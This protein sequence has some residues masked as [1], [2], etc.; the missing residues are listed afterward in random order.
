M[1]PINA[2][3]AA[4]YCIDQGTPKYTQAAYFILAD[5]QNHGQWPVRSEDCL[6]SHRCH[7]GYCTMHRTV[8][9]ELNGSV[10]DISAQLR[11]RV[12]WE[13]NGYVHRRGDRHSFSSHIQAMIEGES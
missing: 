9:R 3:R 13:L 6:R 12:Q 8:M 11:C 7:C 4:R 5:L 1:N 2:A 10:E